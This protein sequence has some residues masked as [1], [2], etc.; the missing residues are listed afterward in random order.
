MT[1][2]RDRVPRQL[3]QAG[4]YRPESSQ[5]PFFSGLLVRPLFW[6]AC[7]LFF[8][9]ATPFELEQS[10]Y[11]Y[12]IKVGA[13]LALLFY[14]VSLRMARLSLFHPLVAIALVSFS[15]VNLMS[16]SDRALLGT[17]A[18][19]LG[20]S[21]GFARGN[22]WDKEF[23]AIVSVFLFVHVSGLLASV[24][25]FYA[26]GSILD[27]HDYLF[28][29]EARVEQRGAIARTAGFHTE[30]GTYSQWT[31]MALFLRCLVTRR[32]F[33]LWNGL[34]A[35]SA[36][37]T[38]SLWGI[39]GF[40]IF[41]SACAI[42][43]L[44]APG[45]G[46]RIRSIL[47]FVFFASMVG[48]LAVNASSDVIDDAVKFLELKGEMTT[49]SGLD[50]ILGAEFIQQHIYNV[51]LVGEPLVPGFCPACLSP[52]DSGVGL[53]GLY[54]FGLVPFAALIGGA[55][56]RLATR[57]NFSFI[58]PLALLLVWKAP[59]YEPLLW[60]IIAFALREVPFRSMLA[61]VR[62]T[63]RQPT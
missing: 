42:E 23:L 8:I 28:P 22:S 37:L 30:P 9:V 40:S 2:G 15:A 49:Q 18:M 14:A 58:A 24:T 34:A 57:W 6:I 41:A 33:T 5:T 51:V 4:K 29:G 13:L 11:T 3:R 63:A 60:I 12:A 32:L 20:S 47:S 10:G 53:N 17:F 59:V 16:P 31:I 27:L 21:L 61:T 26:T 39:I 38:V 54:Y 55:G 48:L 7:A 1:I 19:L 45:R 36:V 43:S 50:K 25:Y 46:R 62:R 52:Q 35:F 44:I 56:I